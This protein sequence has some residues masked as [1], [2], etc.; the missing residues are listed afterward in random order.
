MTTRATVAQGTD[1]PELHEAERLVALEGES[2]GRLEA[3]LEFLR[4]G[5]QERELH[6][7]E[8]ELLTRLLMLGRTLVQVFVAKKGTG[9]VPEGRVTRPSGEELPYHSIKARGYASIFGEVEIPRAY[10]WSPGEKGWFPL[11]AELNL[12]E[13]RYSYLLQEWGELLGADGAFEKVTERLETLLQVKFWNQGIQQ[14]AQAAAEDVQPFYEQLGAPPAAKEGA[15]LVATIDGKGVPI[16]PSEPQGQKL[17]LGPGEKPNK[18]KE[19][20]VSAVY[21]IDRYPRTPEDVIREIDSENRIVP[22]NPPPPPRPRPQNKRMRATMRGKDEA[23]AE[24]RRQLD[25]RDPQGK[26]ERIALTDGA[27]PLQER[28]QSQLAG[29]SGI[30]LILDIMHVLTYL[31]AVAFAFH[32]EGTPEASRWVM[33]KLRLLLEGKVG[34]VIGA[35]RHRLGEGGLS[36][37]K[38][39]DFT[40]AITYMERNRAF[41]AYDVYLAEG[42]PIG[43]GVAEGGCKHLVGDRMESTGMRWSIDGAQAILDL[44]SVSINGDWAAFWRFHAA[45]EKARLYGVEHAYPLKKAG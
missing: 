9:K 39:R 45:Q 23:F 24:V 16:R 36:R 41:M 20:V 1:R 21:T 37:S 2:K 11:D 40:K 13:Q 8:R 32:K 31:W 10:Y 38:Q 17:R 19:A 4:T 7:V 6:E 12:P 34:Y 5:A 22:P 25:E 43:S 18:K 14:V 29:Q 33:N 42:Y 27:E 26:K 30:V 3:I 28:V 44:R 35:L 15:L